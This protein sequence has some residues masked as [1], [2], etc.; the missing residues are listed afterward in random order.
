MDAPSTRYTSFRQRNDFFEMQI[1]SNWKAYDAQN[2][3]GVTIVPDG[4]VVDSGNGQEAIVYGVIVNHYDP[5]G[6]TSTRR[7]PTLAQA[8]QDIVRQISESNTHLRAVHGWA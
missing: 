5:F 7:N 3:Y 1:P 6:G 8:T 4:G 2:G